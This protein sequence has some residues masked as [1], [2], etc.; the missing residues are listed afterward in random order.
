M[1]DLKNEHWFKFYYL[2]ILVSCTGWKDDEFG[3]YI[4]L[5]IHQFDKGFV[6]ADEEELKK[7]I[8]SHKKNWA[9]LS[10]KFKEIEPG[11]L[12]N[13]VMA[14]VRNEFEEKREKNKKNG[15]K[16]GRPKNKIET[17]I[18]PNG[19][20]NERHNI[21]ISVSNSISE[22][23]EKGARENQPPKEIHVCI[24][25]E[26]RNAASIQDLFSADAGLQKQWF[27]YRFPDNEFNNGVEQWMSFHNGNTYEDFKRA[28]DHFFFWIPNY[29]KI[30]ELNGNKKSTATAGK[31]YGVE[32]SVAALLSGD[33]W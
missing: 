21:S 10:K 19:F 25:G 5:L 1:S 11:K 20:K 7:I 2:R 18:K 24:A 3:A 13:D 6:P 32:D 29:K 22:K 17:E 16:G 30:D 31:S 15:G 33:K 27:T 28:R 26:Y 8:T 12:S 14:I 4:K 9:L 23:K